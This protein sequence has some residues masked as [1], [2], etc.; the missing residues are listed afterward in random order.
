MPVKDQQGH[1]LQLTGYPALW[2]V[3]EILLEGAQTTIGEACV[4]ESGAL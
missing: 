3:G 1:V 2:D 4:E